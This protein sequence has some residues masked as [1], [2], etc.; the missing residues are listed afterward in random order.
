MFKADA[1][2]VVCFRNAIQLFLSGSLRRLFAMASVPLQHL[3]YAIDD[4]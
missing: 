3:Q 4:I 2:E 1:A